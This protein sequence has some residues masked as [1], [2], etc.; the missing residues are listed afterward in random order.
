VSAALI[1]TT[2]ASSKEFGPGDLRLCGE[3]TCVP[4]TD[5]AVLGRLGRFIY[6]EGRPPLAHSPRVG[7]PVFALTFRGGYVAGLIG[8]PRFDR[9]RSHGVI[10]GRFRRGSWYRVPVRIASELRAL[11]EQ[12][13][14]RRLSSTV[15]RSC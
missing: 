15:P 11:T 6:A 8:S 14:P 7:A 2:A 9:F 10:C 12:L 13:Q 1:G 3:V 5:R 4:V